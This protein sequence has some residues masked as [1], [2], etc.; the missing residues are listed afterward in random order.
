MVFSQKTSVLPLRIGFLL[1]FSVALTFWA[2]CDNS[3]IEREIEKN[4]VPEN[5]VS[6]AEK[7]LPAGGSAS[8]TEAPGGSLAE[9]SDGSSVEMQLIPGPAVS[10]RNSAGNPTEILPDS[11][12]GQESL[13]ETI[14][15]DFASGLA[16]A[17]ALEKT[18]PDAASRAYQALTADYPNRYEPY[19]RLA[20]LF[21]MAHDHD[22]ASAL[23]EEALRMSPADSVFF[24][25]FGWYLY[26]VRE[27]DRSAAM[28]RRA[29]QLDP[30]TPKYQT[31]L[32]LATAQLGR[33]EEAF[34][35]LQK[36]PGAK[37]SES[38]CTLSAI[39][40]E[41]G[42]LALQAD[43]K[44]EAQQKI[45]LAKETFRK[46]QALEPDLPAALEL[47]KVFEKVNSQPIQQP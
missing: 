39:Q 9:S 43:R 19:H 3:K 21:E 25:D 42:V 37:S 18:D 35:L 44:E 8:S 38:Y 34:A 28:L 1:L 4:A 14:E 36:V 26:S 15:K 10:V 20:L 16:K 13:E 17:Q 31:N 5:D 12:R 6:S 7:A 45:E 27:F 47:Q 29:C 24:N 32:A 11:G 22:A 40:L 33:W 2:G 23:Y 46:S 30:K 41:Q